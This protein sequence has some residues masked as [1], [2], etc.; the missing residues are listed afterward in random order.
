MHAHRRAA[1]VRPRML[2]SGG[3]DPSYFY[4]HFSLVF[5]LGVLGDFDIH[6]LEGPQLHHLD[7]GASYDHLTPHRGD[8]RSLRQ[9]GLVHVW[10]YLTVI[11]VTLLMM[12]LLIGKLNWHGCASWSSIV[13]K[14]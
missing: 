4:K 5:R 12:N 11:V 1:H 9:Y 6:E 7:E 3:N 14:L 10:F 13:L 2:G 8:T